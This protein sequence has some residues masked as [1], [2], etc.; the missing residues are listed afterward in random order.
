LGKGEQG[1]A[2]KKE[3]TNRVSEQSRRR[4]SGKLRSLFEDTSIAQNWVTKKS[5]CLQE[6]RA[7]GK[8]ETFRVSAKCIEGSQHRLREKKRVAWKE[9]K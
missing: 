4:F 3:G 1:A 9:C 5:A 6:N 7:A 8:T 2:Q